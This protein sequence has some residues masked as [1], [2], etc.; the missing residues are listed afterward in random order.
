MP[1]GPEF[2]RLFHSFEHTAYRLEARDTYQ[3]SYETESLRRFLAGEPDDLPWMQSWLD[4]LRD[5]TAAGRRFARV[6]VVSLPLTDYSRFGVW[7]AQFTNGAGEDIR[8]LTRD[9]AEAGGLPD[10]DYWLFDSSKLVR[11]V[12]D[13]DSFLG[14]EVVEDPTEVVR[15]NYWRDAAWHHAVRRDDFATEQH[16]RRV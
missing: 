10:H 8:Y 1:A 16:L 11:M 12:F 7:C 2:R 3:A 9:L 13:A 5:A 6:R 14:G 4:M 15:H